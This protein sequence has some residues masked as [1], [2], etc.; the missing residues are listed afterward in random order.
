MSCKP[1]NIQIAFD[2]AHD[3][4]EPIARGKERLRVGPAEDIQAGKVTLVN[5]GKLSIGVYRI[6][7]RFYAIRNQCPH[8]G[9]PLCLG[10][11]TSTHSPT[12]VSD[13]RVD[14]EGRVLRCPWHGW[15]FDIPS[16][17]GLYDARSRV[18]TYRC[19]VDDEG[20]LW[21]VR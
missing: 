15:E 8:Q 13:Y 19:V 12:E 5:E 21:V 6:H 7:D 9:A 14:L 18:K 10:K 17:K 20:I 2:I 3:S 4:V 1:S 16:G 11:V